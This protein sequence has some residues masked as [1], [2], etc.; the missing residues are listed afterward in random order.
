M[1]IALV[2]TNSRRKSLVFLSDSLKTLSFEETLGKVK[3]TKLDNLFVVKGTYGEYVRSVP[4]TSEKDNLDTLSVTA[5]EI[6]AYANHTRHFNS[7][8]AISL[9]AAQYSASILEQGKPFIETIDGDKAFVSA[10][11]DTV[12]SYSKII[13][14]AAKEFDIDPYLLG[15]ILIDEIVRMAPFEEVWDKF[16]LKLLGRNVSVGVAQVKLETANG[17]IKNGLYNPNPDD[18]KLPF[19]GNLRKQD[20]EYLYEYVVEPKYNLRFA[21]AYIRGMINAWSKYID[22]S[23]RP[24]I[25][26]TLYAQGYGTPKTNPVSIKRGDQIA[27]EFYELA[28]KW[29]K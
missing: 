19:S 25:I 4:N 12:K 7:T 27:V 16:L 1:K 3:S 5:A 26:G 13:L 10:V 21:A 29:L 14:Q 6:M 11:R 8:D 28:K 23:K 17:L 22:L 24:E 9:Y 15:A 20:R 2:V 18:T